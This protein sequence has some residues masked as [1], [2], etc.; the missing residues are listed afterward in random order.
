MAT[1]SSLYE[2][3]HAERGRTLAL[4]HLGRPGCVPLGTDIA[5]LPVP[6]LEEP[7]AKT[8]QPSVLCVRVMRDGRETIVPILSPCG[9]GNGRPMA[10]RLVE[11]GVHPGDIIIA[12][13]KGDLVGDDTDWIFRTA[14]DWLFWTH[15]DQQLMERGLKIL[16]DKAPLD[17]Q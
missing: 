17:A 5:T 13:V 9:H 16:P 4:D 3:Y 6:K 12:S 14:V 10:V 2:R 8:R 1:L 11:S 7:N 15:R